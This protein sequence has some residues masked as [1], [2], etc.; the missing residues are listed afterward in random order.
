MTNTIFSRWNFIK[1]KKNWQI[2][3]RTKINYFFQPKYNEFSFNSATYSPS[4]TPYIIF[5]F[6]FFS[7]M[8]FF[9]VFILEIILMDLITSHI[10]SIY[11]TI[12]ISLIKKLNPV[13][14]VGEIWHWLERLKGKEIKLHLHDVGLLQP[15][16]TNTSQA[17]FIVIYSFPLNSLSV[18]HQYLFLLSSI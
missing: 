11:T 14:N 15:G 4:P 6:F 16:V 9:F 8:I 3:F 17:T 12:S 18:S 7:F 2:I 10:L 13:P 1:I 5:F